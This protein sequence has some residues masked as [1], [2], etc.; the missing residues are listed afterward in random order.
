LTRQDKAAIINLA[1]R[2]DGDHR[3]KEGIEMAPATR[4][5]RRKPAVKTAAAKPAAKRTTASKTTAKARPASKAT[6]AKLD[7]GRRK[8]EA[9]AKVSERKA[10][11][12]RSHAEKIKLGKSIMAR[13]RKGEKMGDI[14]TS[15][16]LYPFQAHQLVALVHVD[17]GDVPA[18]TGKSEDVLVKRLAAA[19][20]KG[21]EYASWD[22]LQ[23]R[24]GINKV[25][26]QKLLVEA[27]VKITDVRNDRKGV[28]T[29]RPAKK[30]P[31][32][33][34]ER[35]RHTEPAKA[36]R[37]ARKPV[38]AKAKSARTR[39]TAAK[40][41]AKPRTREVTLSKN[42]KPP[43]KGRL[44]VAGRKAASPKAAPV[45]KAAAVDKP[46]RKPTGAAKAAA[47]RKAGV[48][49]TRKPVN[50]PRGARPTGTAD[51]S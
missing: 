43:I 51:P 22:W 6:V 32:A 44:P 12:R 47:D 38:A 4:T 42:V 45:A 8:A 23:A 29:K 48:R 31:T 19:R 15:L 20:A 3:T 40:A 33:S 18:I 2:P 16:K 30:A 14:A 21:D 34:R 13:M 50:V 17:N 49:R 41:A 26:I 28:A 1:I 9:A 10:P 39:A 37:A 36:A 25:K 7:V 5:S 27:G 35:Q 46:K 24:S 11:E